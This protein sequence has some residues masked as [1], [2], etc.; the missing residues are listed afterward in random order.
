MMYYFLFYY[1]FLIFIC[2]GYSIWD[3]AHI[4]KLP[5][6]DIENFIVPWL[7]YLKSSYGDKDKMIITIKC[8]SCSQVKVDCCENKESDD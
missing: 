5:T 1:D 8:N 4:Q 7:L 3:G 6:L 2:K